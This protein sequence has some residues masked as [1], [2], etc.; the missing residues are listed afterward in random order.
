MV[1]MLRRFHRGRAVSVIGRSRHGAV[2][3]LGTVQGLTF[4]TSGFV[5]LGRLLI[6]GVRGVVA[7]RLLSDRTWRARRCTTSGAGCFVGVLTAE[8][9]TAAALGR[10]HGLLHQ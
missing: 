3:D 10:M 1:L 9:L 5:R 2:I 8:R 7:H 6:L 4:V